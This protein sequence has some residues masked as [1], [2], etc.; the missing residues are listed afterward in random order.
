MFSMLMYQHNSLLKKSNC[1]LMLKNASQLA[2]QASFLP[3]KLL[4]VF[5]FKPLYQAPEG[6]TSHQH[7]VPGQGSKKD[8]VLLWILPADLPKCSYCSSAIH[9]LRNRLLTTA[10]TTEPESISQCH[11]SSPTP[12]AALYPGEWEKKK[13]FARCKWERRV[14][15]LQCE[16]GIKSFQLKLT[17]DRS[18]H[19]LCTLLLI[20][21]SMN[22]PFQI[23]DKDTKEKKSTT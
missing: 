10:L 14:L 11:F 23:F 20:N 12:L 7:T 6:H 4:H 19:H 13:N 5:L 21:Y 15:G 3:G 2:W 1:S 9:L 18:T 22:P 8:P 17:G 16:G